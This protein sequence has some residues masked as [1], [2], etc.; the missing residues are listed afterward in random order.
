PN[1]WPL[2]WLGQWVHAGKNTTFGLGAYHLAA[3]PAMP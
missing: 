2:L 1:L 3:D